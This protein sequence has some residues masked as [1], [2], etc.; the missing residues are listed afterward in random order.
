M[1][2]N[3]DAS[4]C[5]LFTNPDNE[6][7]KDEFFKNLNEGSI[8]TINFCYLMTSYVYSKVEEDYGNRAFGC[9]TGVFEES[10]IEGFVIWMK[11]RI[12][13]K[14]PD[15]ETALLI[16]SREIGRLCLGFKANATR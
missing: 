7:L 2:L 1:P 13:T 16:L 10:D 11:E 8:F 6:A 5:E 12:H 9:K 15:E 3:Y 4:A 14:D